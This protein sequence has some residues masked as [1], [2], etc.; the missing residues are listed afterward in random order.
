[1]SANERGI[2]LQTEND[3]GEGLPS[4]QV[5]IGERSEADRFKSNKEDSN[6]N[7]DGNI[8][9]FQSY[10]CNINE[11]AL[12]KPQTITSDIKHIVPSNNNTT[13][14]SCNLGAPNSAPES[15]LN[16]LKDHTN[17]NE[18]QNILANISTKNLIPEPKKEPTTYVI[19][20]TRSC[21]L[22]LKSTGFVEIGSKKN[23]VY[24]KQ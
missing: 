15:N 13:T 2:D 18:S 21:T 20:N 24:F 22:Q 14:K 6:G 4:Y 11:L 16:D 8:Q 12:S 17:S 1:M 7:S 19:S 23:K 5:A 9:N 3:L 10:G